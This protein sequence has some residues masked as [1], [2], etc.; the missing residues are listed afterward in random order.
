LKNAAEFSDRADAAIALGKIKNDEEVVAALANALHND[1]AWGIRATAAE[2]LGQL[3]G[4]SASKQLLD[5]LSTANE[6]WVRNRVVS[7]LANFKDDPAV[8]AKLDSIAR[9]D[10]SYRAR[11]AALQALA[12]LKAPSALAALNT[13]VASDSP[14][15]FLRNAA[16]R[17]MGSLGDDKAVPLLREWSSPGKPIDSRQAAISSLARLQKDN[18][19]I[20]KQIV[21][22]INEPRFPIRMSAIF[23]L[24]TRDDASAIPA[25][26]DLLKSGDL[27]IEMTPMI[28]EQIARLKKPQ[29]AKINPEDEESGQDDQKENSEAGQTAVTR[30]LDKLERLIQELNE[31][32]KSIETRLP[33]PKQ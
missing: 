19:E 27:S 22:Y 31:K 33:P 29:G 32:L 14:D 30:R 24:G 9:G 4:A 28:K 25:L 3:G 8:A 18:K 21:S 16:L 20:T 2:T 7:A 11:A 23:A 10:A 12:H 17:A 15:G 13:A 26:E 1:K 6:P 5:A